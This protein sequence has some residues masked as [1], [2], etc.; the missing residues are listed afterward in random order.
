MQGFAME[1]GTALF[2]MALAVKHPV[3]AC[4]QTSL[5]VGQILAVKR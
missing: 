1:S 4:A 5:H 2:G 3:S